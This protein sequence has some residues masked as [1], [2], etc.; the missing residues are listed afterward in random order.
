MSR[1]YVYALTDS[2]SAHLRTGGRTIETV[3]AGGLYAAVARMVTPPPVSEEALVEQDAVVSHL[4][5]RVDAIL[6]MRFGAFMESQELDRFVTLHHSALA[7]ALDLVRGREQMTVRVLGPPAPVRP[8][9]VPRTGSGTD[10]LRSRRDAA[11][12]LPLP[13]AAASVRRA[14]GRLAAAERSSP[15]EGPVRA[16]L[17]HLI[18]RGSSAVYRIA[19]AEAATHVPSPFQLWVSGP[20]PPFAFAPELVP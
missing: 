1:L 13:R 16:T 9:A 4:F 15:G 20:R 7:A 12:P 14:V 5:A 8:A 2:P 10:Y 17:W 11:H 6:P 18:E 19:I 3:S